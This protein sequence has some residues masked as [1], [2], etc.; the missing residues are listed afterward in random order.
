MTSNPD[1]AQRIGRHGSL[2]ASHACTPVMYN[3]NPERMCPEHWSDTP[4]GYVSD[5]L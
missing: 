4:V 5:M 1:T 3:S 2:A